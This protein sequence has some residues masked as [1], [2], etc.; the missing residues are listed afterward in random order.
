MPSSRSAAGRPSRATR[1]ARASPQPGSTATLPATTANSTTRNSAAAWN[2]LA[3]EQERKYRLNREEHRR[4][5]RASVKKNS[6]LSFLRVLRGSV[7]C[8]SVL[9]GAS[10][11]AAEPALRLPNRLQQGQLVIGHAP[12]NAQIDFDGRRLHVG[13]D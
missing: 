3:E 4:K 10:A 13:N 9:G 11:G 1:L 12:A 8:I 5:S 7:F 2:S 6:F